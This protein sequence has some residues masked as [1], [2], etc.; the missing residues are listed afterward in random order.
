MDPQQVENSMGEQDVIKVHHINAR[1]TIF[2][3]DPRND[4]RPQPHPAN[5]G[6]AVIDEKL[7]CEQAVIEEK[8]KRQECTQAYNV[9]HTQYGRAV[10]DLDETVKRNFSLY[11]ELEEAREI[12][13]QRLCTNNDHE[14]DRADWDIVEQGI[15]REQLEARIKELEK[16]KANTI[17]EHQSALINA[18]N[19]IVAAEQKID[20]LG[21]THSTQEWA[22]VASRE[23]VPSP[24]IGKQQR[25]HQDEHDTSP[26]Q[27][28]KNRKQK[29][30]PQKLAKSAFKRRKVLNIP[31]L[32]CIQEFVVSYLFDGIYPAKNIEVALKEVLELVCLSPQS[33]NHH[34]AYLL[35]IMAWEPGTETKKDIMSYSLRMAMEEYHS[36]RCN[37]RSASAAAGFFPPK[38]ISGVG[39]FQDPGPLE[40]D[41]LISALSEVAAMFP[42]IEEPDFV[43]SL[44]TG[45]PRKND[46][47]MSGPRNVWKDGAFPRLCRMYW[48]KI[49]DRKVRQVFRT[50]PR[51]HRLD[52]EFDGPEPRLD[53]TGSM[54]KLK[55]KV[56]T[57]RSLSKIIDN[58]ARC[59]IASLFY[60]E[61]DS[62]PERSNGEYIG[63]GYILCSL[64][65]NNPAFRVLLDRLSSSNARFYLNG[66]L[67]P[68]IVGDPS[69]I[70]R[71]G[72]FRKWLE[73]RVIN[74]F[75]ISLKQDESEPCNIS[76]SPFLIDKLVLAQGLNAFFGRA[77]HRK[78]KMLSDSNV[79][80]RKRQRI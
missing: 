55:S 72:N 45:A 56:Q 68:G 44:G 70:G 12:T 67:V 66:Y 30:K 39:T 13:H 31:F 57:D 15:I 41:P 54:P 80:A 51:Y 73:L 64:R 48:E 23:R 63:T 16:E 58:I 22:V 38:H 65:Y 11:Q 8:Q 50:H 27:P 78:R 42:F 52:I 5:Q 4:V 77:D 24:S 79:P 75:T 36:G 47:S 62:I 2:T 20:E 14:M 46:P 21:K 17:Q 35:I 6:V 40:N 69:S 76:G 74:K 43:V 28:K 1:R 61:L 34:V 32:S 53:D 71:D 9:L 19:R 29:D 33:V 25:S 18:A 37:A 7:S 49:R 60:F 26:R 10:S 3:A 59:V